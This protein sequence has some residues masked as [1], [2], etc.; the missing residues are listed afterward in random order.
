MNGVAG[1]PKGDTGLT[2]E[3]HAQA[4]RLAHRLARIPELRGASLFSSTLPRAVETAA[5]VR[6]AVDGAEVV[7]HC[8]LC[9]YHYLEEHDGRPHAE[10]WATARR[11]GGVT[12]FRPEHDGGDTWGALVLRVGQAL[13]EIA[14]SVHGRTA[15]VVG[16][17][18]TIQASFVVLGNAPLRSRTP[19]VTR[20]TSITEW[21]TD[22]DTTAGGPLDW[23]FADWTLVRSNDTAHLES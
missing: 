12:L 14:E 2:E 8:G 13:H 7:E 18:E 20:Q 21:T 6:A 19:V 15:I 4:A 5:V 9:S 16:H 11:G 1:G 10:A 17:T 23:F 22:D 3:G